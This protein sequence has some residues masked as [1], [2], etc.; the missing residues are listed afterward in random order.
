M[1]LQAVPQ[2]V[3][4]GSP[5]MQEVPPRLWST[6][7][8]N[9]RII[10]SALDRRD[11]L[12][13]VLDLEAGPPQGSICRVNE[14]FCR[15]ANLH[16]P[17]LEG[18]PFANLAA[19]M[20]AQPEW[21]R[22]LAAISQGEEQDGEVVLRL[23]GAKRFW[24]GY[25]LLHVQDPVSG[26]IRPVLTG[27]DITEKRAARLE[28]AAMQEMLSSLFQQIDAA[29]LL[30]STAGHV[31]LSNACSQALLGHGAA[32]LAQQHLRG[33]AAPQD[34]PVLLANHA[35]Q[36]AGRPRYDMTLALRH[37]AGTVVPVRLAAQ[38]VTR[39]QAQRF[40][41]LTLHPLQAPAEA[42]TGAVM[43]IDLRPI[44]VALGAAWAGQAGRLLL[45]AEH[46]LRQRLGAEDVF[47]RTGDQGFAL[48]F[49]HADRE[50]AEAR[51]AALTRELRVK[52]LGEITEPEAMP[53][54]IPQ[55]PPA[56]TRPPAIEDE[57]SAGPAQLAEERARD[58]LA[59]LA[60]QPPQEVLRVFRRDGT[61]AAMAWLDIP[62]TV[63]A[64]LQDA[65]ASLPVAAA[66]GVDADA[67]RQKLALAAIGKDLTEGR[68]RQWL[69]PLSFDHLMAR[70]SR[71]KLVRRLQAIGPGFGQ[72]L[73]PVLVD[74]PPGQH[75]A[76][77]LEAAQWL[78]AL[79][80]GIGIANSAAAPLPGSLLQRPF[81]CLVLDAGE[82]QAPSL[83]ELAL[84]ARAR[85]RGLEILLRGHDVSLLRGWRDCQAGHFLVTNPQLPSVTTLA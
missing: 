52:L 68:Q 15:L 75:E 76:R 2:A 71:E 51:L 84:A 54:A 39:A 83:A 14:A 27:I 10:L 70:R 63:G 48:W 61:P 80:P 73:L 69:V 78:V 47:T 85:Q 58:F 23:P 22:L 7:Q 8:P 46:V 67:L 59:Q 44:R 26:I 6:L 82:R 50:T 60:Q 43:T 30:V 37:R 1:H 74:V 65:V 66:D 45:L 31:L 34:A 32:E 57:A 20:A 79:V 9:D 42:R 24:F 33:L 19:G 3:A 53:E 25:S 38:L 72:R 21:V 11:L 28:A 16:R 40:S 12:I 18:L 29:V 5:P 62:A 56:S 13:I 81:T 4:T 35:E 36:I 49:A 41:L 77:L 64:R 17:Q 55:P